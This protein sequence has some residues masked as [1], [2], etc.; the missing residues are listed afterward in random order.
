MVLTLP[1]LRHFNKEQTPLGD[2]SDPNPRFHGGFFG[3]WGT[4]PPKPLNCKIRFA[5]T[6]CAIEPLK[7]HHIGDD[8]M[9]VLAKV[10]FA[11]EGII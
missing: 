5:L 3:V 11:P 10:G 7:A 8:S 4:P 6:G 1:A 9:L 2:R